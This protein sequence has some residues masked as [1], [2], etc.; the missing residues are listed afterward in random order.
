MFV[1]GRPRRR[2]TAMKPLHFIALCVA[3]FIAFPGYADIYRWVDENGVENFADVEWKVPEKYRKKVKVLREPK[4]VP[5]PEEPPTPVGEE[6][7]PS[8]GVEGEPVKEKDAVEAPKAPLGPVDSQGHDEAW[9]R[10]RVTALKKKK[11]ELEKELAPVEAKLGVYGQSAVRRQAG[12]PPEQEQDYIKLA[13]RRDEIK[14]ELADIDY[15]L[16]EG[17]PDEARKAGA[18]PGWL[19]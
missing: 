15:Q 12:V 8:K 1:K 10:D 19:R 3:L 16:N 11:A 2:E 4:P 17:L 6:A 14:K 18:P 5:K 13:V 9:W 7:Q